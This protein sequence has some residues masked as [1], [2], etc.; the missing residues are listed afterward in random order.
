MGKLWKQCTL[1]IHEDRYRS[2]RAEMLEHSVFSRAGEAIFEP[3]FSSPFSES[4]RMAGVDSNMRTWLV[5]MTSPVLL[6][7]LHPNFG[8]YICFRQCDKAIH[9]SSLG[10]LLL[11]KVVL[12]ILFEISLIVDCFKMKNKTKPELVIDSCFVGL[13][14]F[15]VCFSFIF[16]FLG[17]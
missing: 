3:V 13:M 10:L 11:R 6:A 15:W 9:P 7:F 5:A 14:V 1:G 2:R 4:G 17:E 12:Q 8:L 16:L